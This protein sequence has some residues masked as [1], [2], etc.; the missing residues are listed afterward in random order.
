MERTNCGQSLLSQY[1]NQSDED[2]KT[3]FVCIIACNTRWFR[4]TFNLLVKYKVTKIDRYAR[5]RLPMGEVDVRRFKSGFIRK[6]LPILQPYA[7]LL[8]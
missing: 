5:V 2:A 3:I 4:F 6:V 8:V 1:Q 7:C